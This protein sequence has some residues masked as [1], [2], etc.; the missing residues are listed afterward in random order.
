MLFSSIIFSIIAYFK[1]YFHKK[2]IVLEDT[3]GFI[4]PYPGAMGGGELVLWTW[5][6]NLDCNVIVYCTEKQKSILKDAQQRFNVEI[7]KDIKF[8]VIKRDLFASN[9]YTFLTLLGQA[10]GSIVFVSDCCNQT[11]LPRKFI[12]TTGLAFGYKIAKLYG[13]EVIAYVHYPIISLDMI[14]AVK[15]NKAAFNNSKWI[16]NVPFIGFIKVLY[17]KWYAN[18]YSQVGKIPSTVYV[19]STWTKN[20][21][22]MLWLINS[23]IVYPPCQSAELLKIPLPRS[24]YDIVSVAQ[25]RPE[26]NH[27]LQIRAFQQVIQKAKRNHLIY[28]PH[29]TLIGGVRDNRD[30]ARVDALKALVLELQIDKYVTF[31]VDAPYSVLVHLLSKS[32]IGIHTMLNEHFG[33][34]IVEYMFSGCIVVAHNSGGPRLDIVKPDIGYLAATEAEY[35]STIYSILFEVST[36]DKLKMRKLARKSVTDR[37]S[38]FKVDPID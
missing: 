25:F 1:A 38:G 4:H 15:S 20:H 30:A 17:Y 19:N 37:F 34:G 14:S 27:E 35:A 33:I 32:D 3:V 11:Y 5:I 23:R 31:L 12:D 13:V 29:L 36:N 24:G 2:K 8:V 22:D 6:S 16:A 7:K 10:L 21:I 9:N 28:F 18:W 26:K